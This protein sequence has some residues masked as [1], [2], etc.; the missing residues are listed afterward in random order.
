MPPICKTETRRVNRWTRKAALRVQNHNLT[1]ITP[2]G[3]AQ[4]TKTA[5]KKKTKKNEG[6][7]HTL[8][9]PRQPSPV[10]EIAVEQVRV[11]RRGQAVELED[12]QH[13]VKLPVRVPADGKVPPLPLRNL[14][15]VHTGG[16]A[17]RSAVLSTDTSVEAQSTCTAAICPQP[18]DMPSASVPSRFGTI[19]YENE[20]LEKQALGLAKCPKERR[21]TVA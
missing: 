1:A 3:D 5:K 15:M 4:C 14:R 8:Y 19:I 11:L 13:V 12:V 21:V 17:L 7:R 16:C 2:R 10:Y 9:L 18:N 20:T 6:T